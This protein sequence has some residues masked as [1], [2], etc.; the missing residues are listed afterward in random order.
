MVMAWASLKMNDW[1]K[2]R[3]YLILTF[4]LAAVFLVNKYFEYA[5]HF[6]Q[7]RRAVAQHVPGDLLHADRAARA[8]HHRRH[9][10][11]GCTSSG[12]ARSCGRRTR[13]SSRTASSTRVST[14]TSSTWCGSSCSRC[15]T[16]SSRRDRRFDA[17]S[18]RLRQWSDAFIREVEERPQ[19]HDDRRALLVFTGITVAANPVPSRGAA[20]HHGGARSSR[21]SRA[22]WWRACSCT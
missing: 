20:G 15:C 9:G 3:L 8:A 2:H 18:V 12:P 10:R 16:C 5:E 21:R 19:L 22:R 17:C 11:D 14:G 7:R 6:A 1:A 4:V 13:S